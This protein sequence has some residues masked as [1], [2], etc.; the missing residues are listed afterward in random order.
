LKAAKKIINEFNP[1]VVVGTGGYVCWP[2]IKMAQWMKIP[3][4]IHESNAVCGLVT[5]LLYKK[6]KKVFLGFEGAKEE[7]KHKKNIEVVGI[8]VKEEFFKTD[9][10]SA[11][12]HLG[13]PKSAF[14]ISSF[15]GSGGSQ[16]LN[17]SAISLMQMHSEKTNGIVHI[18]SCG[19]KYYE[20]LKEEYPEYA[21]GKNGC[22]ITPYVENMAEVL[23]ASDII[24][25]RCGALTLAEIAAANVAAIL[26]PSPNVT[27]NH[28]Y[29]NA[30]LFEKADAAVLLEENECLNRNLYDATRSLEIDLNRRNEIKRNISKFA[31]KNAAEIICKK[32]IEL[33]EESV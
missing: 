4:A 13:I 31:T 10:I 32:I 25:T 26:I 17:E 11:R 19:S 7:F 15:G 3:T 12:K 29:K 21:K 2:I 8:P 27:A 30:L 9:K 33:T 14:V 16:C 22:I 28:Q 6:C 1:D 18:H 5:R 20:K 24:I 23:C